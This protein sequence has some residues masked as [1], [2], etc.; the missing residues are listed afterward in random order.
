MYLRISMASFSGFLI[1]LAESLRRVTGHK[2][3]N[4]ASCFIVYAGHLETFSRRGEIGIPL[5]TAW[6]TMS[7]SAA[8]DSVLSAQR[9]TSMIS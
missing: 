8:L 1:D 5:C 9:T 2:T 4:S 7:S 3:L 6:V